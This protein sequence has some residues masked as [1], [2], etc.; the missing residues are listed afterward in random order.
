MP[1]I[2]GGGIRTTGFRK[3]Y[4]MLPHGDAVACKKKIMDDCTWGISLYEKKSRGKIPFTKLEHKYIEDFFATRGI[5]AWT[6]EK[7]NSQ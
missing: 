3:A 5:N 4:M 6:G 1:R 2:R 7:L